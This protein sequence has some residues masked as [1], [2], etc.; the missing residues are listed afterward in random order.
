[1]APDY[2]NFTISNVA[3]MGG[4]ATIHAYIACIHWFCDRLEVAAGD[5]LTFD[6]LGMSLKHLAKRPQSLIPLIKI[7]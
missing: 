1:M 5:V 7:G 2:Y 6:F 4:D 3:P